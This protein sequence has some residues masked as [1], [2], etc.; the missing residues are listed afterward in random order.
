MLLL[1]RLFRHVLGGI[2]GDATMIRDSAVE[3]IHSAVEEAID[4]GMGPDE[5][6]AR[7]ARIVV[8]QAQ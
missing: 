4:S 7:S 1:L 6:R 3:A 2:S 5:F 8:I